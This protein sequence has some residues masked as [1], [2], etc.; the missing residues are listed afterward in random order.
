MEIWNEQR[1]TLLYCT[2]MM[3]KLSGEGWW[4]IILVDLPESALQTL[5]YQDVCENESVSFQSCLTLCD[6]MDSSTP[7]SSVHRISQ[8]RILEWVAILFSRGSSQPRDQTPV[9]CIAGRFFTVEPPG[10]ALLYCILIRKII[11]SKK[12]NLV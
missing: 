9:S 1:C 4:D 8:A 6:P 5:R 12:D 3:S 7:S 10:K 2:E 11:C